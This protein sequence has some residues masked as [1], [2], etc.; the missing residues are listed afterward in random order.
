MNLK[1]LLFGRRLIVLVGVML[2]M[3]AAPVGILTFQ[4]YMDASAQE[5]VLFDMETDSDGNGIPDAF[6]E[7]FNDIPQAVEQGADPASVIR[8]F[9]ERV[10]VSSATMSYREQM[11]TLLDS[12]E[13]LNSPAEQEAAM[14]SITNLQQQMLNGDAQLTSA[15]EYFDKLR[16]EHD[17]EFTPPTTRSKNAESTSK[18][19]S[20]LETGG[21]ATVMAVVPQDVMDDYEDEINRVGDIMFVYYDFVNPSYLYAMDWS[22]VGIYAGD[23]E[24]Y[25][26]DAKGGF[27]C[28]GVDFRDISKFYHEGYEIQYA[29]HEESGGRSRVDEALDW[30]EDEYGE[31]CETSYNWVFQNKWTDAKQY[32]SQLAWKMYK[33]IE[34]DYDVD[35]DSNHWI[36][37]LWLA[38]KYGPVLAALLAIPA[39]APDEVARDGDLDYYYRTTVEDS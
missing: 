31:D 27:D 16:A 29:Q 20:T 30:A 2:T 38:T 35:L 26:S 28:D 25:E 24:V 12:V 34:D 36:Y 3:A 1:R 10:P 39:V 18:A 22:H 8:G 33:N 14:E 13:N 17:A 32:C 19:E 11:K 21:S 15:L 7:G 5:V 6:E 9:A 4:Q 23:S 37:H